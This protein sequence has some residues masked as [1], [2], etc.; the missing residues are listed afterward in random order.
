[1]FY[2]ILIAGS[3]AFGLEALLIGFGGKLIVIYRERPWLTLGLA[4]GLGL[5]V[6]GISVVLGSLLALEALYLCALL[7]LFTIAA[8]KIIGL[9]KPEL[10]KPRLP[11]PERI[12]DR[13]IERDLKKRGI[14]KLG[15]KKRK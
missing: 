4:S 10:V 1:L 11:P 14:R 8:G 7:L 6:V 3:L 5:W 2:L 9:L 12:S 15:R 13:E